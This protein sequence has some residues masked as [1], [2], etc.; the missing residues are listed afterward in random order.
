MDASQEK[1]GEIISL[2]KELG[3]TPLECLE[4]W[5]KEHPEH[6]KTKLSYLGR[7]DPMAEGLMLIA[8]GEENKKRE[9]YLGLDKTYEFEILFGF[10][11]DT[12]DVLGL[13]KVK[14]LPEILKDDTLLMKRLEEECKLLVGNFKKPYPAYSSR[15]V[16]G[17]PLWQWAREGRL[18]EIK[19][20]ENETTVMS[21]ECLDVREIPTIEVQV[22]IG[23]RVGLV[24]GDFRQ[25]EILL[26]WF[27]A[28]ES[29]KEA[30]YY[31]ASCK[32]DCS[33]GTY[34]RQIIHEIGDRLGSGATAWKIKRIRV[35]EH[36]LLF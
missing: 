8:V 19:V 2:Y 3:E 26:Q 17:K 15:T 16:E 1:Q 33:S 34:V 24:E 31:V 35:G 14:A 9:E 20:P 23:R 29:S 13:A 4:R 25:S 5:R 21:L 18:G 32:I 11:T 36:S 27:Q 12:D 30:S 28:F 10:E 6:T 22:E 7:L